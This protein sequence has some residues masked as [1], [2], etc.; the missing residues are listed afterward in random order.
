MIERLE[1]LGRLF[2][3]AHPIRGW[4][5]STKNTMS[6][7][8]GTL[9]TV[10]VERAAYDRHRPSRVTYRGNSQH[11]APRNSPYSRQPGLLRVSDAAIV[12]SY[13]TFIPLK[14]RY[15]MGCFGACYRGEQS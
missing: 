5:V 13:K 11:C 9:S 7:K 4:L 15:L 12:M 3:Y 1:G 2:G 14:P 10:P 6:S 8:R